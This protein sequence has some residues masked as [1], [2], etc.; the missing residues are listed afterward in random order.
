MPS[1]LRTTYTKSNR[2]ILVPDIRSIGSLARSLTPSFVIIQTYFHSRGESGI[3]KSR[4]NW[5][6]KPQSSERAGDGQGD[7]IS[8]YLSCVGSMP[9]VS[10]FS[11]E[12]SKF[13]SSLTL[14]SYPGKTLLTSAA[15]IEPLL[16]TF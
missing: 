1:F 7:R 12:A 9:R 4:L 14:Q 13:S 8:G 2:G 15:S 16:C 6:S 11:F 10:M 3:R 5:R